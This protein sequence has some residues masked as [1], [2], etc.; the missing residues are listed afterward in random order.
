MQKNKRKIIYI[1][2]YLFNHATIL[3]IQLFSSN[4]HHTPTNQRSS[5]ATQLPARMSSLNVKRCYTSSSQ[6]VSIFETAVGLQDYTRFAWYIHTHVAYIKYERNARSRFDRKVRFYGN[7]R[8]STME[9]PV[10]LS[11]SIILT[12]HAR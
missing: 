8:E 12:R 6:V 2:Q 7:N 1:N 3:P 10:L 11:G 4:E 9:P 5:D